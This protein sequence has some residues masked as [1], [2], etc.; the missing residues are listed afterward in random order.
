MGLFEFLKAMAVLAFVAAGGLKTLQWLL[1][2]VS[3]LGGLLVL[4]YG[5]RSPLLL[6]VSVVLLSGGIWLATIPLAGRSDFYGEPGQYATMP[7]RDAARKACE[8]EFTTLPDRHPV[9]SLV[10]EANG[11]EEHS[12]LRLLVQ[13]QL[14]FVEIRLSGN[15]GGAKVATYAS[16]SSQLPRPAQTADAGYVRLALA[17]AGSDGCLAEAAMTSRLRDYLSVWPLPPDQC[18][19]VAFSPQASAQVSLAY[20]L[21]PQ[22]QRPVWGHYRLTGTAGGN[23]IAQLTSADGNEGPAHGSIGTF[24]P[25]FQRPDCRTPHTALADRLMGVRATAAAAQPAAAVH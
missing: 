21:E 3:L 18:L 19:H 11:L 16:F 6:V 17:P 10:D 20:A 14:D 9:A 25:A 5:R 2:G 24:D 15:P 23:L 1:I 13:R 22:P 4:R 7:Q 8:A 12:V